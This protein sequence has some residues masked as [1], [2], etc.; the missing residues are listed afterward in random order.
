M[1]FSSL[2]LFD[3]APTTNCSRIWEEKYGKGVKHAVK[4]REEEAEKQKIKEERRCQREAAAKRPHLRSK[5]IRGTEVELP[6]R[7]VEVGGRTGSL[8]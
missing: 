8:R 3:K 1:S 4:Q 5:G 2:P 6:Q 7:P